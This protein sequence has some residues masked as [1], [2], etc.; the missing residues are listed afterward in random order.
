[1]SESIEFC[2]QATRFAAALQN[3]DGETPEDADKLREQADKASKEL[4]N[5]K[6]L[7]RA[8]VNISNT[9]TNAVLDGEPQNIWVPKISKILA[10]ALND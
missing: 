1:M 9:L 5:L 8:I 2:I 3:M 4:E 7:R 6:S 10:K